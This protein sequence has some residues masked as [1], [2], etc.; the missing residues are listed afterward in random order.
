MNL[1][2]CTYRLRMWQDYRPVKLEVSNKIDLAD[3]AF[4]SLYLQVL[5]PTFCT[6][7]YR[8]KIENSLLVLCRQNNKTT[9]NLLELVYPECGRIY[10]VLVSV[11]ATESFTSST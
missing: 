11:I 1:G 4:V 8:E 6:L 5:D 3:Y 10:C 2:T 7:Y 9:S